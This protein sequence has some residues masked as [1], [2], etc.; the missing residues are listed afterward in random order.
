MAGGIP[1]PSNHLKG[2]IAEAFV[3]AIFWRA[4]YLVSRVGRES[5]VQR[6][7]KIGAD[8][9]LP[10]F[11]IRK[12]VTRE[13]GQR[14]L[15]RLIP[16]EVKYRRDLA[17]FMRRDGPKLFEKVGRAWPDLC[18]ILVTDNP[19]PGRS[20]F[21]VVDVWNGQT[22]D[23]IDLHTAADLDIYERTIREYELLVRAIFPLFDRRGSVNRRNAAAT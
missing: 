19:A 22:S 11:L 6:L 3:E 16:V 7:V 17:G 10:D 15:H 12:P 21:Q 2:R 18:F 13:D 20:C 1:D 9:F 4:G 14:P 23:S 5:Q 8:E